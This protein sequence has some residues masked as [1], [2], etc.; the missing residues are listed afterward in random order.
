[1]DYNIGDKIEFKIGNGLGQMII[2]KVLIGEI[3]T[4]N[5]VRVVRYF[6][7]VNGQKCVVPSGAITRLIK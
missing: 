7:K 1:M 3:S 5:P 6:G 2:D 4:Y